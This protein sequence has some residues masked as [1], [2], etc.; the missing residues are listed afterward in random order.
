MSDA[1]RRVREL[2]G[3]AV[4][5]LLPE[6]RFL[7]SDYT[8][9]SDIY[10]RSRPRASAE[11]HGASPC[12]KV[13]VRAE[14]SAPDCHN[15]STDRK[16]PKHICVSTTLAPASLTHP[17]LPLAQRSLPRSLI[18]LFCS[19]SPPRSPKFGGN[20]ASHASR[21]FNDESVSSRSVCF[22]MSA[23]FFLSLPELQSLCCVAL[24]LQ[25]DYDKP[26]TKQMSTSRA[27]DQHIQTEQVTNTSKQH[28]QVTN[29][30]KQHEQ[31]T[32]TSKE[33]EQVTNTS[34]EQ[35]QVT[36]T[37]KQSRKLVLLFSDVLAAPALDSFTEITAVM[38]VQFFQSGV[39]QGFIHRH[40][41][42]MKSPEQVYPGTLQVCVSFSLI[43]R[44]TPNWNKVGL[45]L[46]KGRDFLTDRGR[47]TAVSLELS[48]TDGKISMSLFP[49]TIRLNHTAL[50]DLGVSPLVLRRFCSDPDSVLDPHHTGGPVWCHVLPSMKKGQ[51]VS[52]ARK[53]PKDGPF[54]SYEE[55]RRH[56][57]RLYGYVL[58]DQEEDQV[59]YCSVYFKPV[60]QTLF[61]YPLC[62][63]RLSPV[64][65]CPRVDLEGALS[66]FMTDVREKLPS[67]CGF[68]TKIS[69]KSSFT[70]TTFNPASNKIS[71]PLNL[72]TFSSSRPVLSHLPR[73]MKLFL[74]SQPASCPPLFSSSGSFF[75]QPSSLNPS[76]SFSD[77]FKPASSLNNLFTVC[78]SNPLTP[79]PP[80]ALPESRPKFVPVFRGAPPSRLVNL[81][82][83]KT[84]KRA[85]EQHALATP[86][87]NPARPPT[88]LTTFSSQKVKRIP[89]FSPKSE[90]QAPPPVSARAKDPEQSKRSKAVVK[91]NLEEAETTAPKPSGRSKK[92]H[93]ELK[94]KSVLK[95][96]TEE[97]TTQNLKGEAKARA[98]REVDVEKMARNNQLSR[99]SSVKMLQWLRARGL[100]VQHKLP[101]D[102]LML[103]VMG[104]LAES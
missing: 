95:V 19:H 78:E 74:G 6:T 91:F 36:N 18:G 59:V 30:S 81:A 61:T 71:A 7:A 11:R 67:I 12:V 102:L 46:V 3:A 73:S 97:K 42:Q 13:H 48:T 27:G 104:C 39:L 49:N 64:Q 21:G 90:I 80:P 96:V 56:W 77:L 82:L 38:T 65:C 83:L 1:V 100:N 92:A 10:P 84:K 51:I 5:A 76:P 62:C 69:T 2:G 32:N 22:R 53:L 54:K 26:R 37:S 16:T 29:T 24:K 40:C 63:V 72:T 33:H 45:Y 15:K 4:R 44:L 79:P 86:R 57:N 14:A 41:L 34:K 28:E 43:C 50:E 70:T 20:G 60:G 58:P 66:S 23:V 98:A 47:L 93:E 75:S 99:V 85:A 103:K 9:V 17:A 68:P 8:G 89:T 52:V 94:M 35:E 88:C 25:D 87:Q 101:K 55:L 31:V